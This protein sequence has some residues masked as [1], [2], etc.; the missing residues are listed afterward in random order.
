M[1]VPHGIGAPVRS[2]TSRPSG[3]INAI[4]EP[5]IAAA[6]SKPTSLTI[7]RANIILVSPF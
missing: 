2:T 5:S 1:P 3:N 6:P 4:T 7:E